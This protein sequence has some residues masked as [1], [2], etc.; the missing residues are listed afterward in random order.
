MTAEPPL[1]VGVIVGSTRPGR[2]GPV[3]ARWFTSRLEQRHDLA[4]DLIDLA[5]IG[6]P[7]VLGGPE[8]PAVDR[9]RARLDAADGFVVVTPEYNHGYPAPLKQA[10]DLAR[11]EWQ[12]KPV[13]F[14]AYGGLAAGMRAVEQ[15]RQVFAEL[16]AVTLRDAVGI[17]GIRDHVQDGELVDTERAER[18]AKVML[19]RLTWWAG[20]LRQARRDA[21]YSP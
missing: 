21:P 2:V 12:A 9:Y 10:I 16:H 18:T 17:P 7:D 11:S 4:G 5:E 1:R 13:G 6:L 3:V 14:V 8:D 20:A 15:L 19:D